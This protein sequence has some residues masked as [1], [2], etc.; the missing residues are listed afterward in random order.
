[1]LRVSDVDAFHKAV[2]GR[3]KIDYSGTDLRGVDLRT[4]DIGNIVLHD[5]L[6]RDADLRGC[7]LRHLDLSVISIRNAK[8][9][10]AYFP[11]NISADEI[12][13]S[14]RHGTRLHASPTAEMH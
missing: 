13:M 8:I 10:G 9:G 5:A 12:R 6:L 14:L 1:M 3:D 4:I 7:D 2:A 11:D